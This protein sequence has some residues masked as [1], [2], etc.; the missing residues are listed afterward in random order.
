MKK[1]GTASRPAQRYLQ[2]LDDALA[3]I[4]PSVRADLLSETESALAGLDDEQARSRIEA[5]GD[6]NQIAADAAEA[7][8]DTGPSHH[9]G[10]VTATVVVLLFGGYLLPVLG[11]LAALV[12]VGVGSGW[13][14][15]VRRRAIIASLAG[16]LVALLI[17]YS[18]HVFGHGSVLTA[19]GLLAAVV[20]PFVVNAFTGRFL[21]RHW[22]GNVVAL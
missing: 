15:K 6:P 22:D 2:Q 1:M 18:L 8:A 11:W 5:L 17:V 20:V 9:R 21:H 13:T 16:G 7:A 19:S 10:Y 3:G 4:A 14:P 12:M